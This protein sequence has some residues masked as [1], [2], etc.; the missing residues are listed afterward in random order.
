MERSVSAPRGNLAR[1]NQGVERPVPARRRRTHATAEPT[2][3]VDD[4]FAGTHNALPSHLPPHLRPTLG[5]KRAQTTLT[6]HTPKRVPLL[7]AD[8]SATSSATKRG[9]SASSSAAVAAAAAGRADKDRPSPTKTHAFPRIVRRVQAVV[10]VPVKEEE[11]EDGEGNLE[12]GISRPDLEPGTHYS[13]PIPTTAPIG[14]GGAGGSDGGRVEARRRKSSAS[15]HRRRS[16]I[17]SSDDGSYG[18]VD[19]E[20]P[21]SDE[22]DDDDDGGGEY[23]DEEEVENA[24]TANGGT[25]GTHATRTRTTGG[26]RKTVPW[27]RKHIR[28]EPDDEDDEL[29]MYAKVR[30]VPPLLHLIAV[31]PVLRCFR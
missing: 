20:E 9:A 25:G 31:V 23:V 30:V 3:I 15:S 11:E 27:G 24:I 12:P 8:S 26:G 1:G 13:V 16:L 7:A 22:S 6:A 19:G 2:V 5:L 29:M 21:Q 28:P 17:A 18:Y 10:E 4:I 14:N